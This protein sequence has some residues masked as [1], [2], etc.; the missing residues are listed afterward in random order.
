[1]PVEENEWGEYIGKYVIIYPSHGSNFA[2][3]ITG[4]KNGYAILN[5]YQGGEYDIKKGLI[6]MLVYKNSRVRIADCTAIEPTT[7]K[8][9]ENSCIFINSQNQTAPK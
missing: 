9:L 4:L 2:G 8:N 7:K 6:R 1:M 3:R 5:P